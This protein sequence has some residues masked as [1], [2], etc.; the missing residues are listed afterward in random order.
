MKDEKEN[1]P[2]WLESV[3]DLWWWNWINVKKSVA[4][5]GKNL[6]K[7]LVLWLMKEWNEDRNALFGLGVKVKGK[8]V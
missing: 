8:N 6:W 4:K 3:R 7:W 5:E 2:I 1:V